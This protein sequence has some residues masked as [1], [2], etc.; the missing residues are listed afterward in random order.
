MLAPGV[1]VFSDPGNVKRLGGGERG[2]GANV[3]GSHART[4]L[5]A[6]GS[7]TRTPLF[8]LFSHMPSARAMTRRL[9]TEKHHFSEPGNVPAQETTK[10]GKSAEVA[11]T[12]QGHNKKPVLAWDTLPQYL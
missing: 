2:L 1:K 5:D 9:Q 11:P 12:M 6:P 7:E 4:V 10:N 3:K 8:I